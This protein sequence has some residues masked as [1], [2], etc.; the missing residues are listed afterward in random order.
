M[1]PDFRV[2]Q[3]DYL[4]DIARALAEPPL[5]TNKEQIGEGLEILDYV[6]S[7]AENGYN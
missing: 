5:C 1:L 2:R 3:R 7:L 4:L 6:I